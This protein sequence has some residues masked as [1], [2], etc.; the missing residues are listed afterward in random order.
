MKGINILLRFLN[1]KGVLILGVVLGLLLA[2]VVAGV[3]VHAEETT[4]K[5]EEG[6]HAGSITWT[7]IWTDGNGVGASILKDVKGSGK[8]CLYYTGGTDG[9]SNSG[10]ILMSEEKFTCT[11]FSSVY[12]TTTVKESYLYGGKY[13]I[14][15]A[16]M[17][18]SFSSNGFLLFSDREKAFSYIDGTISDEDLRK[19]S[20]YDEWQN[21]NEIVDY[22][23]TIPYYDN[24]TITVKNKKTA[25]VS[26]SMSAEQIA[27]YNAGY[28]DGDNPY[29]L[30][31]H[32]YVIYAKASKIGIFNDFVLLYGVGNKLENTLPNDK[33][34]DEL[35]RYDEEDRLLIHEYAGSGYTEKCLYDDFMKLSDSSYLMASRQKNISPTDNVSALLTYSI[36][37]TPSSSTI[38]TGPD[39]YDLIGFA[40]VVAISKKTDEG[41]V[42][43]SCTYSYSWLTNA[44]DSRY[45]SKTESYT[46]DGEQ[47]SG[48]S[49]Y[50][51]KS[52]GSVV[53]DIGTLNTDNVL[54]NVKNGF[55]LA[56]KDGYLE[57]LRRTFLGVPS[58]IW[59]LVATALG[60]NLL[61]IVFKVLRGM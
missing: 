61:V 24:L 42:T 55:G 53:D 10:F 37:I 12:N 50:Y 25:T 60:I 41:Y 59:A 34:I 19:Y 26:A 43:G 52:T 5:P 57:L 44:I 23:S 1:K 31:L 45:G 21:A 7:D 35:I 2:F 9:T 33:K 58:Y 8:V 39:R 56:G 28:G 11:L 15:D 22:D 46:P 40:S 47:V 20:N 29:V 3:I 51:D 36:D 4:E 14:Y 6:N 16:G 17:V 30:E 49:F 13:Q 32:N 18:T 38:G 54:E 27:V 48:S